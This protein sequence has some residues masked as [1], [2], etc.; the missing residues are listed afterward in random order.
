MQMLQVSPDELLDQHMQL[1]AYS[2]SY[3]IAARTD[4]VLEWLESTKQRIS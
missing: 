3:S 4:G 2:T 1:V